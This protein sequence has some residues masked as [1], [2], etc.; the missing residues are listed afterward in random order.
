MRTNRLLTAAVCALALPVLP[1]DRA[2]AAEEPA[3]TLHPRVKIST[4][5]GDIIVELDAEKAPGTVL[6]FVQYAED[7]FYEGTIFHRVIRE[8]MIQGGGYT[9]S[10]EE[11]TAGLRLPIRL[12]AANGLSNV[13]GTIA[14]ARKSHPD[15]ATS[16]F[17]INVAD[18]RDL[19][20]YRPILGHDGYAVFGKV[21]EGMEVVDKIRNAEVAMHPRFRTRDGAV[22]PTEPVVIQSVTVLTP[23]DK[24]KAQSLAEQLAVKLEKEAMEAK[25]RAVE[26]LPARLKK[27]ESETGATFTKT[28]SGLM[29]M[30]VRK[31]EGATPTTADSVDITYVGTLVDGTVFD[32]SQMQAAATLGK[33]DIGGVVNHKLKRLNKGLQEGIGGMKEGGKRILVIPPEL[34]YGKDGIPGRIPADST[35]FYEVELLD[36]RIGDG[37]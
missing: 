30:D 1:T 15:S 33:Y 25:A 23:L 34:A 4:N 13:A 9:V 3:P 11:K 12:E 5:R 27:I 21:V 24:G 20:D 31:G 19:L 26:A 37:D 8:F 29:Y 22:T 36:V 6:N 18:N 14:M 17:F 16:Q 7:K 2:R 35:I 28:E 32:S 10:M